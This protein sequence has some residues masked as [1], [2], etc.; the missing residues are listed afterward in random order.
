MTKAL[1]GAAAMQQVER[2]VLELDAPAASV[3]PA[4]GEVRVLEGFDADGRPRTRARSGEI[5]L[6]HLLTHTSGFG[7]EIFSQEI[8]RYKQ[9]LGLPDTNS[10]L[11]AALDAPLLFD[12]GERWEYGTGIDWAGRML[13]AV[14]GRKL[15][16]LLREELLG[17][18][19]MDDTAFSITPA[20]RQRLAKIHHREEDGTLT[21]DLELEMPQQ[22]EFEAGGHALYG[23]LPDYL[24]FVRML[25]NEGR[26]DRGEAVLAPATVAQMSRNAIGRLTVPALQSAAPALSRDAE[27]FPGIRKRW[28]L[29]FMI[30][31]AEAPTGRSA[32]SLAWAGLANSFFWVDPKRGLGGV[33]ATQILPFA[34]ERALAAYYAFEALAYRR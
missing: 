28:G 13:E 31:D 9:A 1:V 12:P 24:K 34:D 33:Y 26:T 10:G 19:G 27:F 17:P 5:T 2:G 30:N 4:L 20:M 11:R 7:Y 8:A 25:L 6:R 3:L 16:A 14:D 32:G 15:G 22:A 23:T 18:L 21:P 29:S